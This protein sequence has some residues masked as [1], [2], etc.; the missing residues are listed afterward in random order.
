[1]GAVRCFVSLYP[2]TPGSASMLLGTPLFPTAVV[3]RPG[4]AGVTI[5]APGADAGHPYIDAVRVNGRP[6]QRSWTGS[7]LTIEGGTL[8]FRLAEQPT[9]TA[10]CRGAAL[11]RAEMQEPIA[12]WSSSRRCTMSSS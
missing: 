4:G 3:D 1:M 12:C 11:R 6:T 2:Q 8:A 10:H 5:S 7:G 9:G